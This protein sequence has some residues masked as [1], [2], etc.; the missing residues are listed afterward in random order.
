MPQT[1]G[2]KPKSRESRQV[3]LA[4]AYKNTFEGPDGERVLFDLMD[5]LYFMSPTYSP[6]RPQ[7]ECERNEGM[8][9][10]ILYILKMIR[11]KPNKL[12]EI[13]EEGNQ[14]LRALMEGNTDE[15]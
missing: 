12:M 10:A 4:V 11:Y 5:K 14:E 2:K 1:G 6:G 8:R 3:D 9:E 13:Y 15:Y 7:Y